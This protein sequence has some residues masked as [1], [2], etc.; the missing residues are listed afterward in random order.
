MQSK[1]SYVKYSLSSGSPIDRKI[2]YGLISDLVNL[3][4]LNPLDKDL[5][6]TETQNQRHNVN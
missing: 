3:L 4:G 2:K 1:I 5:Y 6:Q